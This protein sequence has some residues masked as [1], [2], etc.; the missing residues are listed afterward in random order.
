MINYVY[1]TLCS[2][3][4]MIIYITLTFTHCT[5]EICSS[6]PNITG[7][8]KYVNDNSTLVTYIC[9]EGYGF[10]DQ[11]TNRTLQCDCDQDFASVDNCTG[12]NPG[13]IM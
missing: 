7:G 2:I 13:Y 8:S 1:A 10:P 3:V 5:G 12:I 11:S 9:D 4:I 6:S